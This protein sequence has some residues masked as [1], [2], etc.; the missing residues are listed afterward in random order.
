MERTCRTA[1]RGPRDLWRGAWA[2]GPPEEEEDVKEETFLVRTVRFSAGHHYAR[3]GRSPE[4]NRRLF[5]RSATPHGHN[6]SL[7]VT[8]RGVPDDETGF[9]VDLEALDE[10]LHREVVERFDQRDL[11]EEIPAVRE[12]RMQPSTEALARWFFRRLVPLVPGDATL[13]RV[14]LSESDTLAAEFGG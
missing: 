12:G 4:E 11:N 13:V 8:V 2:G 10:V 9:V 1:S 6:F 5:G 7:E 3:P 14:R